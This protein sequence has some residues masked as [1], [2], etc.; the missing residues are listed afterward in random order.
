MKNI[1][2]G[3]KVIMH[4]CREAN[5]PKYKDKK[6]ECLSDSFKNINGIEV[7]FLNGVSGYFICKYLKKVELKKVIVKQ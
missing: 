1:K 6:I 2:K 3:D 5:F 7:V 4:S